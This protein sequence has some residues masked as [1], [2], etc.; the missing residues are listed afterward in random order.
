LW[1]TECTSLF[2]SSAAREV[3]SLRPALLFPLLGFD[4][5]ND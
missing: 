3:M 2:Q 1:W 5:D 4:T